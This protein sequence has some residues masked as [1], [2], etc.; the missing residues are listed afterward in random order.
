MHKSSNKQALSNCPELHRSGTSPTI[1][2]EMNALLDKLDAIGSE[3]V[4]VD[5]GSLEVSHILTQI[6]NHIG[7]FY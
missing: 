3:I 6:R 1:K 4:D 5:E 7:G 2:H